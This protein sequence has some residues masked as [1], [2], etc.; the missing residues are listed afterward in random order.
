MKLKRNY[1]TQYT[2]SLNILFHFKFLEKVQCFF[3][4]LEN[5]GNM[6]ALAVYC[7]YKVLYLHLPH[8]KK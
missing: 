7:I 6:Y 4:R 3:Q 2:E 8:A 5:G 1:L